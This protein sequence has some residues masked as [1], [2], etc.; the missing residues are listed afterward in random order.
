MTLEIPP[1]TV[2]PHCGFESDNEEI[3]RACGK[4]AD[5]DIPVQ[6]MSLAQTFGTFS[7]RL[8]GKGF[9]GGKNMPKDIGEEPSLNPLPGSSWYIHYHDYD[10][11]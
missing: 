3:C 1:K 2:C 8:Q 5:G 6:K 11:D 10:N 7:S 9:D 4:L